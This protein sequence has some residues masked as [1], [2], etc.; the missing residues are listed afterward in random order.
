MLR[1]RTAA[2]SPAQARPGRCWSQARSCPTANQTEKRCHPIPSGP[3]TLRFVA[4]ENSVED[5]LQ[6]PESHREKQHRPEAHHPSAMSV[7]EAF[8]P[9]IPQRVWHVNFQVYQVALKIIMNFFTHYPPPVC[10]NSSHSE[11]LFSVP[12][13]V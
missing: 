9:A 8:P 6:V 3:L 7:F 4:D 10:R 11:C 2:V 5:V 13:C 1:A 12:V